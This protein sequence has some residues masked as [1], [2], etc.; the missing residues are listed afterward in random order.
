MKVG[1]DSIMLG[2]WVNVANAKNILDI[3]TGSGLL[4]IMLAQ[5]VQPDCK[6]TG[7]DLDVSAIVQAVS[8]GAQSP[9]AE[10]LFFE[11]V[12]LQI[13]QVN[14]PFD[15]IV[16]N[17]PYFPVNHASNA[18]NSDIKRIKAR[19]ISGLNHAE[20]LERVATLL[21]EAGRFYCVLPDD[22]VA[23]FIVFAESVGLYCKEQLKVKANPEGKVIRHLLLFSK[24]KSQML[25]SH[26][27]IYGE[28]KE[29]YSTEYRKLCREYYLNF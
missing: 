8:N 21:T 9:W 17:P 26:M 2:S 1:T 6:I 16:S 10:Q 19:Q 22:A 4:A 20:L 11:Q 15:L 23:K 27:C 7:I 12:A 14:T 18:K 3:G 5:N 25:I 29:K 24:Q 28:Q 13:F